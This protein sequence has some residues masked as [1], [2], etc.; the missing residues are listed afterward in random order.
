MRISDWSSDVCSSDL[1]AIGCAACQRSKV[2][3]ILS[4]S[5]AMASPSLLLNSGVSGVLSAKMRRR[6]MAVARVGRSSLPRL[7]GAG[8]GAMETLWS[9]MHEKPQVVATP[10]THDQS[11]EASE[12]RHVGSRG[13]HP[14]YR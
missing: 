7:G 1:G 5:R 10:R 3:P 12:L 14:A 13:G 8:T 11:M 2:T 4:S 9:A 6:L